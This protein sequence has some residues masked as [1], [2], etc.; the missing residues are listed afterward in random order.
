MLNLLLTARIRGRFQTDTSSSYGRPISEASVPQ[1]VAPLDEEARRI[2]YC[3]K[4]CCTSP[5]TFYKERNIP[6]G[7]FMSGVAG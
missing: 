3:I 2:E 1:I 5:I 7:L 6:C 4:S